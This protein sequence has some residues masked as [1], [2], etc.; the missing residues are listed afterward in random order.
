MYEVMCNQF[1][2]LSY[3]NG[4]CM[5][6]PDNITPNNINCLHFYACANRRHKY[7][8]KGELNEK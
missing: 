6:T 2:C 3:E 1:Q 8:I 7:G 5:K 4:Y